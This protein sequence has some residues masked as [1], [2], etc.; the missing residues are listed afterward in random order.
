MT[1]PTYIPVGVGVADDPPQGPAGASVL[2]LLSSLLLAGC[3]GSTGG[4]PSGGLLDQDDPSTASATERFSGAWHDVV[5]TDPGWTEQ[6]TQRVRDRTGDTHIDLRNRSAYDAF[7]AKVTFRWND[8]AV[9]TEWRFLLWHIASCPD[10]LADNETGFCTAWRWAAQGTSPV[11]VRFD[12]TDIAANESVNAT[13]DRV[14]VDLLRPE[15]W[16]IVGH[17]ANAQ[18]KVSWEAVVDYR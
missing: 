15:D 14:T 9:E 13:G 4:A 12:E 8:S 17:G 18:Q 10:R 6:A 11:T 3:L 16:P 1:P 7:D 5:K 2:L